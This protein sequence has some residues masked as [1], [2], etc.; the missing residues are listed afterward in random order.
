MPEP[1]PQESTSAALPASERISIPDETHAPKPERKPNHVPAIPNF[2]DNA[3][4]VQNALSWVHGYKQDFERQSARDRFVG[5]D[6]DIAD[7]MYRAAKT[8]SAVETDESGNQE[9]TRSKVSSTSYYRTIR[10]ITSGE[11]SVILGNEEELPVCYEPMPGTRD[12]QEDEGR[13]IADDQNMTLAYT[14]NADKMA[15]TIRRVF[16]YG[17]KYGNQP[18]EMTWDYRTCEV[19][20]RVPTGFTYDEATGQRKPKGFTFKKRDVTIADHPHLETFGMKDYWF[21]AT[22]DDMQDQSCTV[23]CYAKQLGELWQLQRVRQFQNVGKITKDMLKG[24]DHPEGVLDE[25]Q[26]NAGEDA[27]AGDQST[28]FEVYKAFVRLP[29]NDETGEWEPDTTLPHWYEAWFAGDL[30]KNPVCLRL[31]PWVFPCIP[32]MLF[33]SHDDDKGALHMGFEILSKCL[34]MM[35]TTIFNQAI[36]NNTLRNQKPL[37]VDR[38]SL[39][40]RDKTF[41]AGGNRVWSLTP[42]SRDPREIEIQDT[43][44]QT[45]NLLSVIQDYLKETV[46]TNKPFLGEALGSRTSASEAMGVLEQAVKPALE[47][48][49]YKAE[50]LLPFIAEW[51]RDYWRLFGDPQ[52]KLAVTYQGEQREIKP[53]ELWGPLNVRVV[54]IKRFSD[55]ILQRKQDD[56][57]FAQYFPVAREYMGPVGAVRALKQIAKRRGYDNVDEWFPQVKNGDAMARAKGENA[58]VLLDG[59]ADY[60]KPDE[61][62]DAHLEEHE[63]FLMTYLIQ[64]PKE[65]QVPENVENMKLHIKMHKDFKGRA[66]ANAAVSEQTGQVPGAGAGADVAARSPGE[67]VGDMLGAESGTL[68]NTESPVA[69]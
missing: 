58:A 32:Q 45:I 46:G 53:A 23:R 41:T 12:Y 19:L 15:K 25:R 22:I 28:L 27:D 59:V 49:K 21:D 67:A 24:G 16:L 6:M 29:I 33:H 69:A 42:G 3:Q 68:G 20:E 5:T 48:A 31:S 1:E 54:S 64:V 65:E 52:R 7:E 51:V 62:H 26:T 47:D 30:A 14:M 63:P 56:Q 66:G 37:I 50:Q 38:G 34:Y 43:T 57:F 55:N 10:A 8:R 44:G 61:D 13:R 35:E 18:V 9:D 11:M 39:A 17:N 40:I 36:D 2:A 60:P 4:T